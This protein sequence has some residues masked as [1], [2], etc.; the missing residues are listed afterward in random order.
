[1]NVEIH[2]LD[3]R[4]FEVGVEIARGESLHDS[5]DIGAHRLH[6]IVREVV[7]IEDVPVVYPQLRDVPVGDDLAI[8]NAA[9]FDRKILVE[10]NIDGHEVE[11]AVLGNEDPKA[12]TV[13]EIMPTVEF[14]DFDAKYNN[15]AS[16][17]KIPADIPQ[18][19]REEYWSP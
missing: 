14:Y 6:E 2:Q 19:K 5:V 7:V 8:E 1:M 3:D 13:G 4:L 10:E 16:Q 11:C 9:Q 15:P 18:E 17:T 12:A